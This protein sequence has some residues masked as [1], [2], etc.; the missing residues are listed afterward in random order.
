MRLG[1]D[2]WASPAGSPRLPQVR[3]TNAL[4]V[5]RSIKVVGCCLEV[6]TRNLKVIRKPFGF[7]GWGRSEETRPSWGGRMKGSFYMHAALLGL[8]PL[9][10]VAAPPASAPRP[11]GCHA[12]PGM[13]RP[14]AL[15]CELRG[16]AACAQARLR[17]GCDSS[18][19]DISLAGDAGGVPPPGSLGRSASSSSCSRA[20]GALWRE[21]RGVV[22][23]EDSVAPI[24]IVPSHHP[25]E[26]SSSN[27]SQTTASRKEGSDGTH[28]KGAS[29]GSAVQKDKSSKRERGRDY[30]LFPSLEEADSQDGNGAATDDN[31][32]TDSDNAGAGESIGVDTQQDVA[33]ELVGSID[34][35]NLPFE[36]A[37]AESKAGD[38]SATARWR[39]ERPIG[40]GRSTKTGLGEEIQRG[41]LSGMGVG[42]GTPTGP[43]RQASQQSTHSSDVS[44]D[45]DDAVHQE[46]QA[47]R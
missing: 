5:E 31:R 22:S 11:R 7:A 45:S 47:R 29:P 18:L 8:L 26:D 17:G 25:F 21:R 1:S 38:I 10:R 13:R 28:R 19:F 20:E 34:P 36:S 9:L 14:D 6:A 2:A 16:M 3:C 37:G 33:S 40:A 32:P 23:I 4:P 12:R 42:G 35:S 24:E 27:C 44:P 39:R 43:G 46:K 15:S 41:L 30:D